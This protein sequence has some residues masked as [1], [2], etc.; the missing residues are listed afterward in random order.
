MLFV[1]IIFLCLDPQV[2]L[3]DLVPH[4]TFAFDCIGSNKESGYSERNQS[5]ARR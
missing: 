2:R 3:E 4:I 5:F 1:Y